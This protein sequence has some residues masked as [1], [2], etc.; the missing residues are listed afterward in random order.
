MASCRAWPG[1]H[2]RRYTVSVVAMELLPGWHYSNRV[3]VAAGMVSA[4]AGCTIDDALQKLSECAGVMHES[5]D[6]MAAA[7]IQRRVSFS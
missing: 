5:M 6:D 1:W 2:A 7:V 4:Q 3:Y